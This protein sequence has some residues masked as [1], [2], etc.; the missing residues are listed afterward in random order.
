M[1]TVPVHC[2]HCGRN[3]TLFGDV[4]NSSWTSDL[5]TLTHTL[6]SIQYSVWHAAC[7]SS[8]ERSYLTVQ[9]RYYLADVFWSFSPSHA[10]S[11]SVM[12]QDFPSFPYSSGGSPSQRCF[13]VDVHLINKQRDDKAG[14]ESPA[15]LASC[16]DLISASF[17]IYPVH[18]SC[19]SPW[20]CP[21]FLPPSPPL[22]CGSALWASFSPPLSW[23]LSLTDEG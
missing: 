16:S 21:F 19:F 14:Q 1:G 17:S 22:L 12:T 10:A 6:S 11:L 7:P 4:Y 2:D 23:S 9:S 20:I 3:Q 15:S 8:S 18:F 13:P 5:D